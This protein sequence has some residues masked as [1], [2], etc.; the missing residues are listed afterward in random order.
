MAPPLPNTMRRPRAIGL[1]FADVGLLIWRG[2]NSQSKYR[3][4]DGVL[5]LGGRRLME[6]YNNQPK[7]GGS[8]RGEYWGGRATAVECVGGAFRY[9]L[10]AAN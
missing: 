4:G 5:A 1:A 3:E 10:G 2:K 7:V 6:K 9:R 8:G